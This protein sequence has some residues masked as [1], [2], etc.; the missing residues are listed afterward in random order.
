MAGGLLSEQRPSALE[1]LLPASAVVVATVEDLDADLYPTEEHALGL[2]VEKRRREFVTARSCARRALA[3]LGISAQPIPA[4]N[5]GEPLWPQGVVGSITHCT[6]YRA[7]AVARADDLLAIGI[8]AEPDE[9]LPQGLLA[10]IALPEERRAL[11]RL[12]TEQSEVSWERLLFSIK[13][14][15]YKAWFPLAHCWL[16]FEDASVTIDRLDGTFSAQLLVP[17][18]TLDGQ[19][20]AGF[21]GRWAAANG[22]LLAVTTIPARVR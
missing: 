10:D 16:G 12:A 7:C 18:P 13:E 8:D 1:R 15:I 5:R 21:S 2:A 9:P 3:G 4:G 17:G 19:K 11:A 22:L 20:L 6:G 14:A